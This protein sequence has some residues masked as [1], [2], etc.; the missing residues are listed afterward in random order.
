M[1]DVLG[2]LVA[3]DVV[4]DRTQ[5]EVNADPVKRRQVA[6][7]GVHQTRVEQNHRARRAFGADDAT[8][9]ATG[10]LHQLADQ[11]IVHRPQ[12]VAGGG[13]VMLGVDH[14]LFVAAGDEHQG[15]VV[16]GDVVQKNGHVHRTLGRHQV[17]IQPRAVILVPLPDVALKGHLAVDLELVHV[18]RL[19]QQLFHGLNHARM[20]CQLGKGLAV[21]VRGK[22]GAHRVLALLADVVVGASA[23]DLG[24]S[25][26][27]RLCFFRC[28]QAGEKQ[29]AVA[30]EL[31]K[32]FGGKFH[33]RSPGGYSRGVRGGVKDLRRSW[34]VNWQTH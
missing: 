22:V 21:H 8:R 11:I 6:A 19:A 25:V 24:H 18:Q 16:L 33:R 4:A 30:V 3:T 29:V 34:R 12:R 27:Q 20:A 23:V 5:A 2:A 13:Q 10:A 17:V 14:A 1:R 26:A 9:F 7:R 31:G 32:L 28:K 15:A